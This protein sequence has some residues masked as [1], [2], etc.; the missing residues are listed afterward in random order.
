[1]RIGELADDVGMTT[2]ALR[3]YEQRGLLPEP[4]RTASGYRDY[5]PE[6]V[7]RLQFI[8]D[9]QFAGL[10]LAEIQSV[11]ELKDAGAGTCEHTAD[12]IRRHLDDLDERIRSLEQTRERLRALSLRAARLDPVECTDPHRCQVIATS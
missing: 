5:P 6:A 2:K 1:M 4:V 11:L 3:F 8:R 9:S 10:T 12:L 7:E